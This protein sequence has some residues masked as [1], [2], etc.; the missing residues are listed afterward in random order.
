M[1]DGK[2]QTIRFHVDDVMS[3]HMDPTVNDH[4]L[5]WLNKKHGDYGEV[6]AT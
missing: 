2:Q 1:V 4:F 3:S 5:K 6:K